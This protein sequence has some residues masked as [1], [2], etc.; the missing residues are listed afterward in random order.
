MEDLRY[1]IGKF[2][3][4]GPASPEQVAQW[5]GEIAAAPARLRAAVDGLTEA[6]IETP[7]R[8]GGWTLHQVVNHVPDSHMNAYIRFHWALTE[9]E[10]LIKAY[11]EDRWA[12][13]Y[14]GRTTPVSV[15]LALLEA[16][17]ARWVLLL[18][19]LSPAELGKTFR[20]SE[21]GSL[22][23]ERVIGLYA[24]H[25]RHHVAHVTE[26]RKRMGW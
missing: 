2:E 4:A 11:H 3:Y 18:R 26:L 22:T 17:H 13:L 8:P 25:G 1:P 6:Q 19:S 15:S 14:D 10:P 20:H 7:Y 16:L 21:L 9:D 12:E 23:L 24:W 5:I